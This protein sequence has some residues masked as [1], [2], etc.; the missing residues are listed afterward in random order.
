M[1]DALRGSADAAGDGLRSVAGGRDV[2]LGLRELAARLRENR[3][4]TTLAI[5]S[6]LQRQIVE[7]LSTPGRGRQRAVSRAVYRKAMSR[8]NKAAAFAKAQARAGRASAPGDPPAPDTGKLRGSIQIE[9]DDTTRIG[10]CG[11]N[12]ERAAPLN[13]G[14][15]RAGKGRKVVILPRPFM[16]PALKK[17]QGAMAQAGALDLRLIV[18]GMGVP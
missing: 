11:T 9:Y 17:A 16:E 14:T 2:S 4:Q 5:L 6:V 12:D 8:K 10:R 15:R 1:S 3:K 13:Y 18:R 7:E